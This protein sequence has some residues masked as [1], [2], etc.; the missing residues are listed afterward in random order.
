MFF[1]TSLAHCG[2]AFRKRTKFTT[3][4]ENSAG[5]SN[6]RK[7]QRALDAGALATSLALPLS[8]AAFRG[9]IPPEFSPHQQ[10]GPV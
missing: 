2:Q 3:D 10:A 9:H 1:V 6:G 4:T 5:R 8:V 7:C